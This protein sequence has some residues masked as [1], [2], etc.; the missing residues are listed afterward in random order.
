MSDAGKRDGAEPKRCGC[1]Y[2][3]GDGMIAEEPRYSFSG[4][5]ALLFG[6]TARPVSLRYQ[7]RKCGQVLEESTDPAL[8][9]KHHS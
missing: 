5:M 3:K 2:A 7:C 4:T 8:L 9:T 6:I 1:G